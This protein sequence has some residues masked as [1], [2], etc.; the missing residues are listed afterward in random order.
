MSRVVRLFSVYWLCAFI[1]YMVTLF[2]GAPRFHATLGQ[3]LL[4]LTLLQDFFDVERLD[5][6]YWT[7]SV[8]LRF[9]AL[10]L[11]YLILY[12][13]KK[14]KI[15][16]IA[17]IWL[18]LSVIHPL[19]QGNIIVKAIDL[20]LIFEWSPAFISGMLM[21]EIYKSKKV[22]IKNGTAIFI[23]FILSIFHRMI[24]AKIAMIKYQETFSKPI[25]VAVMFAVYVIMLLVIL[26]RLKWLNKPYFLYLGI[27]T[28]PLYLLHQRIGYIIFNNLMGHYNKY[29]ILAGTIT[30]MI[31]TS[32]IIV[33]YIAAPLSKYFEK[34]LGILINFFPD[35]RY[36]SASLETKGIEKISNSI[37]DK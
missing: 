8:E 21:A 4:N 32:F 35:L 37:S 11:G 33:K 10:A 31:T 9:Y 30:L 7:M 27:M 13:Y 19:V 20:F 6:A 2:F 23:C 34:Y 24:Y 26:G 17:Y 3:F 28:Y 25:I 22:N 14:I 5:G 15:S 12:R 36:K 29:L 18:A 16:T 1:T